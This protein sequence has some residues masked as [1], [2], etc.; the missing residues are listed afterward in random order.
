M[1]RTRPYIRA[2]TFSILATGNQTVLEKLLSQHQSIAIETFPGIDTSELLT[3]ARAMTTNTLVVDTNDLFQSPERIQSEIIN[4]ISDDPTF[5]IV[6]HK[7]ISDLLDPEKLLRFQE[8][9]RQM[10][11]VVLIGVLAVDIL[12]EGLSVYMDMPRWQLQKQYR[13]GH[14]PWKYY[15][16]DK[17]GEKI[18][19]AS[20]FDW[21]LG[22]S[23]R[24]EILNQCQYYIDA[25]EIEQPKLV[26]VSDL[27]ETLLQY[28]KQPFRL[29]PYFDEGV[30]GGHWIQEKFGIGKNWQNVAWGFDG[31]PEE[32]SLIAKS[33]SGEIEIP[34]QL[35]VDQYPSQLMG[36][37]TFG[38]YGR[39]FP[40]RFDYL[41]TMGGQNLSLQVHPTLDYAYRTFG[42]KYT[43]DE[44]YYIVDCAPGAKA[45]LGIR[46][47][48]SKEALLRA[49]EE[50]QQTGEFDAD[51]YINQVEIKP[52]DH[53]LIPAGTIHSS[54]AN[55]V[56]LEI[57]ATPNRYTFKLWDWGRL[58]LNQ[59]PRPIS[60]NHGKHVINMG[61]TPENVQKNLVNHVAL[62]EEN[63][64]VKKEVTGLDELEGIRTCRLTFEKKFVQKTGNS[65]N[66]ACLVEGEKM[67]VHALR[68]EFEDFPVFF[69]ETFIV[70]YDV[71]E[72]EL[73]PQG[74]KCVV[75]LATV[76]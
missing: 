1:Y 37:R 11:P 25:S 19:R 7:K 53:L 3:T 64:A 36:L 26:L 51:K 8:Q 56:V 34:A 4:Q 13:A 39:D 66:M 62:I 59:Q 48:V 22:E 20:N 47:G 16:P 54:G 35:L 27:D 2:E 33:T 50:A 55:S 40:I 76:K 6:A 46:D 44:S 30:W 61:R 31:V 21:P 63:S 14:N 75:M 65:V 43:Q 70:P 28:T 60:I 73:I 49:L 68:N 17:I 18:R 42:A 24:F 58:D 15:G 45:Y 67:T 74:E 52:H 69:G 5:G 29:V 9:I 23:R 10:K 41:D 57:S 71:R 12:P 32:N 38:R 72:Y